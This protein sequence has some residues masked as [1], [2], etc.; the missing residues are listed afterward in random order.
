M[1]IALADGKSGPDPVGNDELY[2]AQTEIGHLKDTIS[3]LRTQLEEVQAGR[4]EAVQAAVA[5]AQDEIRQLH[6]TIQI[7]RDELQGLEMAKG[8]AVQAAVAAGHD[9]ARQLH[10]AVAALRTELEIERIRRAVPGQGGG[11]ELP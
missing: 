8:E 6:A 10:A 2:E 1:K 5:A 3:A 7:L 4:A 11:V 9:E